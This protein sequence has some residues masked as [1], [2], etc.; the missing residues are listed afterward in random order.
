MRTRLFPLLLVWTTLCCMQL[1]AWNGHEATGHGLRLLIHEIPDVEEPD[2]P[3]TVTVELENQSDG[4][5]KGT[6]N[7]ARLVDGWRVVGQEKLPLD[8]LIAPLFASAKEFRL[9][10]GATGKFEFQIVAERPVYAAL[11]PVHVYAGIDKDKSIHAVR[12]FGVKK[13][14][15]KVAEQAA[16]AEVPVLQ[17]AADGAL[18][19]WQG[20][21]WQVGWKYYDG[22]VVQE[23]V[24]WQGTDSESRALAALRSVTRGEAR[25]AINMHPPWFPGGGSVWCDYRVKLPEQGPVH[26][27]VGTAIR[28]HSATEPG[29][30]GVSFRVYA[31]EDTVPA[32]PLYE[33]F[34][35]AKVWEDA[36]VDLS[37][38]AGKTITLRLEAHPGPN[39]NTS[40]DSCYWGKP[41]LVAGKALETLEE[42]PL[43]M[44]EDKA[45]RVLAVAKG[46]AKADKRETF[47]LE[48]AVG[49]PHAVGVFPGEKGLL[50]G[51]FLFANG[52]EVSGFSGL[53]V[54]IEDQPLGS[55]FSPFQVTKVET[56]RGWGKVQYRHTLAG[57]DGDAELVVELRTDEPGLRVEVSCD[58]RISL[59][60]ANAWNQAAKRVYWGH[61]Y[62]IDQPE[63]FRSSFGGHG[64]AS[65]HVAFETAKGLAV[66][67][68]SANPPKYLSVDPNSASQSLYTSMNGMLTFVPAR[69]G[70]NAA[71]A[72]RP[73]YD[74]KAAGGVK[75]LA[76][77]FC[78]DIWGGSAN[79]IRERMQESIRYGLTDSFL[80]VHNWQR[81]GYDYRLPDIWPPRPGFGTVEETKALGDVCRD[82]D[83]PWGLHDNYIDFYPDAD[84]YSYEHIYFTQ[85]GRPHR[86]WHNKGR[87]A[88]SYKW[89]PDK[90][91]PFVQRNFKMVKA[92]VAPTHCFLDVFTST[93]CVE[94]WDWDGQFHSSLET[95]KYWGETFA[96][97]RDYL[98]GNA[99]T[100][101]EAGHDQLTGY[102]DG[103]DCQWM[104]IAPQS[105]KFVMK[106]VCGDWERVP[107]GSAVIHSRFI[108]HGVGYSG[109]YQGGRSRD[110]HGINSDD[111]MSAEALSGHAL[112]TDSAS[113]GRAVIRKY[114]L[115]QDLARRLALHEVVSCDFVDGDIHRQRVVWDEG[116]EVLVNRGESD[117]VVDGHTLPQYGF[118]A[119][120]GDWYVAVERKGK[121]YAESSRGESGWFC[122]ARTASLSSAR[123]VFAKPTVE[124]FT[125]AG[126]DSFTYDCVWNVGKGPGFPWRTFVHFVKDRDD[127][128]IA[129]QDD[130]DPS[131]PSEE[132]KPGIVRTSRKVEIPAKVSGRYYFT[133]GMYSRE[134]GRA[135]LDGEAFEGE[136]ILVGEVNVTRDANGITQV[137]FK[138]STGGEAAE[139]PNTNPEGT[140]VD[141]GFA[142]TSGAFRVETSQGGLRLIPLPKSPEFSLALRLAKFG[143]GKLRKVV[144]VQAIPLDGDAASVAVPFKQV[145]NELDFKHDPKNFAYEIRW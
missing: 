4:E 2:K 65:S 142:K 136:R 61:G 70:M 103:A 63:A 14:I 114:Y 133:V 38:F 30:D 39:K 9:A 84:D 28:D 59:L 94:W 127:S 126:G 116:T 113:W 22:D 120:K 125:Y 66:L 46:D 53:R 91:L 107:W 134:R 105:R 108:Q 135:S 52:D 48:G 21:D 57:K 55:P 8:T 19:L 90:I 60:G 72:Y 29:S 122:D 7:L 140:V 88:F 97:I 54:E 49:G 13:A 79:S 74:K 117:W 16:P 71:I 106:L 139:L 75:R 68:A 112:M 24:R 73:L 96:W 36:D 50:D 15:P 47:R 124:N 109:R 115:M 51:W 62:V 145:G 5:L 141:F 10:A 102:L 131:V 92:G 85:D 37:A 20:P 41:L 81:W 86:A 128:D 34:S 137:T 27:R 77:R 93:G 138:P 69:G 95:R 87:D 100:T 33:H 32:K 31:F 26:F 78:F 40:C 76:G 23:P 80:T 123:R 111:Y 42:K 56:K 58:R 1:L 82:E 144:S 12:I 6:L 121:A 44:P 89:R 129:F 99:P 143:D 110:V 35:A 17:L 45:Q 130:H 132:W 18:A 119:R 43:V 118:L 3:T 67:M 25:P 83:I 11:Y 64:F 98:G 101:S 104:L